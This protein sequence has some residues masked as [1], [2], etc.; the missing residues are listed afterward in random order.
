MPIQVQIAE[1]VVLEVVVLEWVV[2]KGTGLLVATKMHMMVVRILVGICS[3][4][5][6]QVDSHRMDPLLIVLLLL[7]MGMVQLATA[8]VMVQHMEVMV[9]LLLVMVDLLLQRMG[10]QMSLMLL[11]L[12]VAQGVHGLLRLPLAMALWVMVT[13]LLGVLQVGVLDLVQQLQ[14]NLL[15]QLLDMGIKVMGMVVMAAGMVE[16]IIL[17]GIQVYMV[18]LEGVLGVLQIVMLVVRVVVS[19]KVVV[20]VAAIWAAAMGMQMEILVMEMQHGD[21]NR[22]KH[23]VIMGLL[24]EMVAKLVMVVAMV[25]LS[26]D[27]PNSS[28]FDSYISC[29]IL[30]LT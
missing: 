12:L 7:D 9:V 21:L 11:M 17:M 27:K 15:V 6:L 19:C 3:L 30:N 10:T 2:I 14:V 5:V 1:W 4:K 29:W 13:L 16:V 23:L 8:L 25:V 18:L 28:N 20:A 24:K 26:L 22:L